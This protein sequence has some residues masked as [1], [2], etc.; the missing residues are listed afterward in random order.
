MNPIKNS[1]HIFVITGATGWIGRTIAQMLYQYLG[2]EF[3]NRVIV[4]SN[5]APSITLQNN[6]VIQCAP[7]DSIESLPPNKKYI[8]FHLAFLTK[9]KVSQ[10]SGADYI[11]KNLA[12]RKTITKFIE[13]IDLECLIYAS[14]GAV[15]NKDRTLCDDFKKNPYGALKAQDERY[16]TDLI[17]SKNNARIIIPRI[18][19]IGGPYINKWQNYALSSFIIQALTKG[20]IVINAKHEVI[21]SYVSIVDLVNILLMLAI[22]ESK[23]NIIFDSAGEEVLEIYGIA[24]LVI[25]ELGL[26]ID[27][28]RDFDKKL[29]SDIYYGDTKIQNNIL[30]EYG[31]V[32]RN[33]NDI[34]GDTA[35]YLKIKENL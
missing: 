18:F 24:Q 17:A 32:L 2:S 27:I 28:I 8:L 10:M 33:M 1:N 4:L 5:S 14:S 3:N 21:R 22:D 20:E 29:P 25:K 13:K 15:Y 7:F 9:D 23:T 6:A 16:F 12:I 31:Y 30:N 11:E 26:N 35:D 19:N 34:V